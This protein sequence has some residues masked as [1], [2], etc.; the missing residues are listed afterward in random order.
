MCIRDSF[1]SFVDTEL[2]L[3]EQEKAYIE[4]LMLRYDCDYAY[5]GEYDP[6]RIME[7][8][9]LLMTYS[10]MKSEDPED[11]YKRQALNH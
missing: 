4:N 7:E 11:V 5:N 8:Y 6:V 3:G 1:Y 9:A 2:E 10:L